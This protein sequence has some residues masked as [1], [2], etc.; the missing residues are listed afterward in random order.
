MM[1]LSSIAKIYFAKIYRRI[2]RKKCGRDPFFNF[3][4]YTGKKHNK[5]ALL[6]YRVLP[7]WLQA[8]DAWSSNGDVHSILKSLSDLGYKTDIVDSR[9]VEFVPQK[10]YD[11]FI[12]HEGYNYKKISECLSEKTVRIFFPMCAYWK[13]QNEQEEKRVE[14]LY[15]R[16]GF[17]IIPERKISLDE[18]YGINNAD[19]VILLS[20]E[21]GKNTYPNKEKIFTLEGASYIKRATFN[22][23]NKNFGSAKNNFLFLSGSGNVHKGLDLLLEA[24]S[25]MPEKNLYICSKLENDFSKL[26]KEELF[27]LPNIHY[28]GN[29]KLYQNKFYDLLEK[30]N[31]IIFPSCSEGS[32][33]SVI[34]CLSQ[35]LIPLVS[36]NAHIDIDGLGLYIDPCSID[37]VV[38]TVWK[39]S[40]YDDKWYCDKSVSIKQIAAKRFSEDFYVSKLGGYIKEIVNSKNVIN[41]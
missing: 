28:I 14:D 36:L 13:F 10:N 11:L 41:Q 33:G 40:N 17:K 21:R 30:C 24:F 27:E 18:D 35:G 8:K 32:P 2:L 12:G 5:F 15:K 31:Y 19:G 20:N 23:Q 7:V 37:N 25:K 38:D 16:K 34:D 6:S 4:Y 22:V 3:F 39:I 29:I 1:N 26:Y 9:D